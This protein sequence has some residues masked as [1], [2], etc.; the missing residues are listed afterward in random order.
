[1]PY[2]QCQSTVSAVVIYL[3]MSGEKGLGLGL[4]GGRGTEATEAYVRRR[5]SCPINC[6][7]CY[8]SDLCM[9]RFELLS[10]D[11]KSVWSL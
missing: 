11:G 5:R 1:M 8:Q 6:T 10:Y 7:T 3:Y 2:I 4:F 9:G